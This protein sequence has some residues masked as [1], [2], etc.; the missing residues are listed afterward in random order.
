MNIRIINNF[1]KDI[2]KEDTEMVERKGIGH[3]DSLADL[4]AEM[5]SNKYSQYCIKN[6]GVI[7]NHWVDKILISGAKSK[8]SFGH[9][10]VL[11]PISV[12]LFGKV[13]NKFGKHTINIS[14]IFKESAEEIFISIFKN[15]DLLKNIRYIIDINDGIGMDHVKEFYNP[16]SINNFRNIKDLEVANDSVICSGYAGY[17][18]AEF[19][20]IN[21]ECFINSIYFKK[22]FPETG[23]D[24]KILIVRIKENFDITIC[25]PFIAEMT[26]SLSF[27]K[28]RLSL[29]KKNIYIKAKNIIKDDK[30]ILNINTKDK[31]NGGYITVFGTSLDKGDYGVVGRGNRYNGIININREMSAEAVNGKNPVHHAGKLY[32]IISQD[33][34]NEIYKKFKFENYVNIATQN[35]LSLVNPSYIMMKLCGG[36]INKSVIESIINK[37]IKNIKKYT[38]KIVRSDPVYEFHVLK[39][40]KM[41]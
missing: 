38:N 16:A 36:S 22:K 37:K 31:N 12:Y 28:G 11:K 18:R 3:P 17:S 5:F 34:A 13:T 4:I 14:K 1:N 33:I 10:K 27:Y 26:K 32:N 20:A 30:I 8:I 41:L 7:L 15:S 6:F 29:V 23:Y 25:I 19:L 39:S 2:E 24:V 35:G 21:L 9:A 40:I